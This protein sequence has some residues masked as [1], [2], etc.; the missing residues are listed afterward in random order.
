M[1]DSAIFFCYGHFSRLKPA[2]AQ[3][4]MYN[5]I[6]IDRCGQLQHFTILCSGLN[7]SEI[8]LVIV[9]SGNT[10][11]RA[12]VKYNGPLDL[13]SLFTIMWLVNERNRRNRE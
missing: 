2:F 3:T 5:A 10:L 7:V 1:D 11:N 4:Y 8:S 9:H 12:H 6:A 13:P